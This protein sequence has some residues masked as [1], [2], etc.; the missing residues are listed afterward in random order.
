MIVRVQG[1][2]EFKNGQEILKKF[3]KQIPYV[4]MRALNTLGGE[5]RVEEIK[6]AERVFTIRRKGFLTNPRTGFM[7]K[8]ASKENLTAEVYSKFGPFELHE[9]GGVR[10]PRRNANLAVPKRGNLNVSHSK[11]IPATKRPAALRATN[12]AFMKRIK[13]TFG[14]WKRVGDT[15]RLLYAFTKAARIRSVFHFGE[16]AEK[17]VNKRYKKVFGQELSK[18]IAEAK[19][20]GWEIN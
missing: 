20:K 2:K 9:S 17:L 15:I 4:S 16:N 7:R 14:I 12:K 1:A 19:M 10:T 3:G 8:F 6:D 13:G 11:I 18:A 5:I